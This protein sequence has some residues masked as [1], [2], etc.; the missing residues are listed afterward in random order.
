MYLPYG[1]PPR[2]PWK[3]AQISC[4]AEGPGSPAEPTW[5]PELVSPPGSSTALVL[6][7]VFAGPTALAVALVAPHAGPVFP[8]LRLGRNG[9]SASQSAAAGLRVYPSTGRSRVRRHRSMACL[10]HRFSSRRIE[11]Q[12]IQSSLPRR[13]APGRKEVGCWP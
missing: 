2:F 1:W 7:P 12:L 13:I 6:L 9:R 5:D 4:R 8:K 3:G 10:D 11:Q